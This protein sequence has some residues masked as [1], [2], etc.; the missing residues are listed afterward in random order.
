[1][2]NRNERLQTESNRGLKYAFNHFEQ[3][4]IIINIEYYLENLKF[5]CILSAIV[6][7]KV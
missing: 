7:N 6:R 2:L 3:Q 5:K 1:M 4:T